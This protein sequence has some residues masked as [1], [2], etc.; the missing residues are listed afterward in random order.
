MKTIYV[1]GIIVLVL[2][3]MFFSCCRRNEG[4]WKG[5]VEEIDG[6][7]FIQNPDEP[8]YVG[9]IFKW[10]EELVIERTDTDSE[11]EMFQDLV[12]LA[13]DENLD[14]YALDGKAANIKVFDKEGQIVRII[15]RRGQGPGE[16]GKPENITISPH[17]EIVV[18]DPERRLIHFFSLDGKI[19]KHLP[20]NWVF[21]SG[22]KFLSTGEIFA[23]YAEMGKELR[24][25]LNKLDSDLKSLISIASLPMDRP[26]KVHIFLYRFVLDLKWG[27]TPAD[28]IIWGR[29][30]SPEYE[31][32]IHDRAGKL[33]KKITKAYKPIEITKD[34][35]EKLVKEW[36]GDPLSGNWEY[37][38]PKNYPPFHTF[39]LDDEGRIF[40]RRFEKVE[41]SERHFLEV[42][43]YQGRYITDVIFPIEMIPQVFKG[44]KLFSIE[45]TEAGF[46]VI[47]RYKVSWRN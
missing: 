39:L 46:E 15:G 32:C 23:S 44:R 11:E 20:M 34:E 19:L 41:D 8:M 17:D 40:V 7:T 37:I 18:D 36:F 47:K 38:I 10:E 30:T 35:Y 24:I 28:E 2:L 45:E 9:D 3:V 22:P 29:M 42:F 25:V 14:I 13:V 12:A 5:T 1:I 26:P 16:F 27:I 21:Y 6:V 43:D 33:I 31:F 4:L